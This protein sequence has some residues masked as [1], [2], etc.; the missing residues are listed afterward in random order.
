M[1]EPDAK[2]RKLLD[3][4]GP[5]EDDETARRKMRDAKV[6]KLGVISSPFEPS[7]FDPDNVADLKGL[8]DW[9]TSEIRP[10]GYFAREGDLPMMR[11]LYVNGADIRDED[12]AMNFPLRMALMLSIPYADSMHRHIEV[13]KWLFDHGADVKRRTREAT[14]YYPNGRSSLLFTFGVNGY[15]Y[16]SRL[17]ILNGALCKDDDSGHLDIEIMKRD[18][19]TNSRYELDRYVQ[20]R[21]ALLDWANDLHRARTSFL[22]FLSGALSRPKHAH[23]TRRNVSP[24]RVL[25]GKPGILELIGDYVGCVRGRE[26]R[27]VRQLTEMLPD[28]LPDFD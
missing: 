24:L 13:C 17:L 19:G 2:R 9:G 1:S 21:K 6:F 12:V 8:G 7:G 5:V 23:S 22:L 15:Q 18:L 14:S 25:S 16:L 28:M 10:M 27:I 26:A 3:A 4:G 20:R 11:W